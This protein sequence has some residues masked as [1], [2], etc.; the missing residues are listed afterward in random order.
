[1]KI[2]AKIAWFACFSIANISAAQ[3]I[4]EDDLSSKDAK[5]LTTDD[6]RAAHADKTI[7]QYNVMSGLRVPIWYSADGT[8]YFR[9]GNRTFTGEWSARED[10]RC[11][12]TVAGPVVCMTL[13]RLGDELIVCDPREAPDCRWRITRSTEGDIEKLAKP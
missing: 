3:T 1:M 13:Y 6:I 11:E 10:K 12:E 5:R 8:R 2:V 9:G 4:K 7:I